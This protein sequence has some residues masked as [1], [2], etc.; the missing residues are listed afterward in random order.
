MGEVLSHTTIILTL[1]CCSCN[2]S[3][4][5]Q[6]GA[7]PDNLFNQLQVSIVVAALG[8]G[9]YVVVTDD[10]GPQAAFGMTMDL[11]SLHQQC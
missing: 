4:T 1:T 3:V 9:F 5:M 6:V 8:R 2:P 11:M 7:R 10:G